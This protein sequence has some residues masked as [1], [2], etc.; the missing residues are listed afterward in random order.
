VEKQ[1]AIEIKKPKELTSNSYVNAVIYGPSGIGKTYSI[2]TAPKPLILSTEEGLL[3]IRDADVDVI[4]I[5]SFADM[6]E[7]YKWLVEKCKD[8]KCEYETI[9]LDSISELAQKM[10]AEYKKD[11]RDPRRAYMTL[12]EE[13]VSMIRRFRSLPAHIIF[14]AKQAMI[15]DEYTGKTFYGPLLPGRVLPIE[16][17]Y[18]FD[19]VLALRFIKHEGKEYRV[20]QTQ[21]DIQYS[22]KDRSGK[23]SQYEKPNLSALFHKVIQVTSNEEDN[24][25]GKTE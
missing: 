8:S 21:P 5:N 12:A 16:V 6:I 14:M 23:L 11:E 7:A 22:C 18:Q 15:M 2:P 17:P 10:L 19:L 3:S 9:V 25:N 24:S 13:I 1:V 20:L 4:E